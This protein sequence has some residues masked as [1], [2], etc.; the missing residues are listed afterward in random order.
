MHSLI[1]INAVE[2]LPEIKAIYDTGLVDTL[3]CGD[4]S[5]ILA[6]IDKDQEYPEYKEYS[7]DIRD[8]YK[9]FSKWD[10]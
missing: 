5:D 9:Q 4:Y 6:D 10:S 8:R 2:L 3:P 1:D 7:L